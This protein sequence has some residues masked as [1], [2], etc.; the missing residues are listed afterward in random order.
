MGG[1][2]GKTHAIKMRAKY[3][4]YIMVTMITPKANPI[5]PRIQGAISVL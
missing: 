4:K 1:G 3:K 2:D 5:Y